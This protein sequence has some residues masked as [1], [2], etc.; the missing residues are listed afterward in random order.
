MLSTDNEIGNF[1]FILFAAKSLRM[2][3]HYFTLKLIHQVFIRRRKKTL[4][5]EHPKHG[6]LLL[7]NQMT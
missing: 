3:S 6:K 2:N 4:Y 1:F 5:R 7:Q